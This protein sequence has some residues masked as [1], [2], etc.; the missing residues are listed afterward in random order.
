MQYIFMIYRLD[1]SC[2]GRNE[3]QFNNDSMWSLSTFNCPVQFNNVA[4]RVLVHVV[5]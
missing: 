3:P 5:S 1:S 2:V 4:A